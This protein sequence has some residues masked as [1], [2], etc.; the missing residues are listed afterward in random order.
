MTM[1][2]FITITFAENSF[3]MKL[4]KNNEKCTNTNF[5]TNEGN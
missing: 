2:T 1:T 5:V 3:N 4:F